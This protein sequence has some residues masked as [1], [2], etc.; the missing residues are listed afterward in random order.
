MRVRVE[1]IVSE[2]DA[3]YGT[4]NE[5]RGRNSLGAGAGAGAGAG[6]GAATGAGAGVGVAGRGILKYLN[7]C[8][9]SFLFSSL[10][11]SRSVPYRRKRMTYWQNFGSLG[12]NIL[13]CAC[14]KRSK[15][16]RKR[17]KGVERNDDILARGELLRMI[18]DHHLFEEGALVLKQSLFCKCK[19][20]PTWRREA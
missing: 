11:G 17:K 14:E 7:S 1:I 6:R 15:R 4:Y 18:G 16:E 20:S 10:E 19:L 9:I 3:R 8:S 12:M 2:W 13:F 5:P